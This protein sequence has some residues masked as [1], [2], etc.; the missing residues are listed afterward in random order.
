MSPG[1]QWSVEALEDLESFPVLGQALIGQRRAREK[2]DDPRGIPGR[3][4]RQKKK[5]EGPPTP[6]REPSQKNHQPQRADTRDERQGLG[7][8]RHI[9]WPMDK[10]PGAKNK[11]K[12]AKAAWALVS[13]RRRASSKKPRK[14]AVAWRGFKK[15]PP[16][17]S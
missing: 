2:P 9:S 12:A 15:P 17:G 7:R 13:W 11:T 16:A 3:A 5:Q 14:K 4:H 8:T 1:P 10:K 6:G